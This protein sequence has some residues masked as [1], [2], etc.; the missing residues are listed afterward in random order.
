MEQELSLLAGAPAQVTFTPHL[1]P[2]SRGIL[3]TL[4]AGLE[5]PLTDQDVYELYQEFYEGQPFVRLHAPG[6]LPATA[7]VRGSNFCDLGFKVDRERHRVIVLSA[8]DNL[9]RGAST[10]A[11]HNFNLMAGLPETLGLDLVPLTP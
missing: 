4:Y 3:G 7:H 11:V 1:V 9:A 5:K 10:Q 6:S 2:M 8:I